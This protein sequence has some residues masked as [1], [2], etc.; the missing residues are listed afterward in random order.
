[1]RVTVGRSAAFRLAGVSAAIWMYAGLAWAGDGGASLT[2]IQAIIGPPNGASGFCKL[3]GMNPCPQ[4]P[5]VT[6]AILEA[7]GLGLS[8]PEMVAAQNSITP[9]SNVTAGNPAVPLIQGAPTPFPLTSPMLFNAQ[10][11]SGLLS[12]LTPLAFIST[13]KTFPF[14]SFKQNN[15]TTAAATQLYDSD[16]DT[17][18]YGVTASLF[19]FTEAP[20]GTVPDTLRLFYDDLEGT[21][22]NFL[23]GQTVAKFRLLLTVLNSDGK[24]ERAVPAT[25]Q[26]IAPTTDCSA[27]KVTGD[28]A[29]SGTPQ[30]VPAADIGLNCAVV[31]GPSPTS[32][33]THA[34]FEVAIPLLVTG[35]CV[36]P[37]IQCEFSSV[38]PFT[39]PPNTDPAYFYSWLNHDP[40]TQKA[41]AGPINIGLFTAF[42]LFDDFGIATPPANLGTNGVAIGIA[43]SAGPLGSPPTCAGT[44]CTPP[45]STFALCASLPQNGFFGQTL[46]PAVAAY[47]VI[48]TDGETFLS[49]ALP[50]SSTSVCP[51]L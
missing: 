6:Q 17:F 32:M 10:T 7:A 14:I 40:V 25:L 30:T 27:S 29:G 51:P 21:N 15:Q 8:P 9:G 20:G 11:G 24:T 4:L 2:T 43:P 46:V 41:L 49:A 1:M 23:R 3:L 33:Q 35:A 37:Q 45:P 16:A 5:T 50:A 12:T 13:A 42:A 31:F 47:D 28:F 34:I 48:A 36:N 39:V 44:N 38:P 22:R 19:G 18:F 26:F